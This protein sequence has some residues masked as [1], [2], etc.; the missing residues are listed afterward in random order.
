VERP[1]QRRRDVE[2]AKRI[3]AVL[4]RGG[5]VEDRYFDR[6]LPEALREKSESFWSSVHVAQ[7]A[8]RWLDAAGCTR[9]LDVGAGVG[10]FCAVASLTTGR[11]TWGLERRGALVLEARKLAQALGAEVVMQEGGLDSIDPRPFDAFYFYNPF[12][13]HIAD[14]YERIDDTLVCSA[15]EYV[16]DARTVERWLRAAKV[17]TVMVTYNG[18]GGRIPYSWRCD[19]EQ[20]VSGNVMRLWVK[21]NDDPSPDAFIEVEDRLVPASLLAT[22]VKRSPHASMEDALVARLVAPEGD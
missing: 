12:A 8:A 3:E 11:C 20:R 10:K 16:R 14:K 21:H 7:T 2:R 18:L 4:R 6:L 1:V 13:E 15:D 9:V 22:L 17:G 19:R 5:W